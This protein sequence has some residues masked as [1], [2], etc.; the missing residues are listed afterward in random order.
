MKKSMFSGWR[1]V[2]AFTWKQGTAGKGFRAGTIGMAVLFLVIGIAINM[3]MVYGQKKDAEETS[4]IEQVHIIDESGL[5][6]LYL[7]GFEEQNQEK[8]PN[9]SFVSEEGNPEQVAAALA[10]NAEKD[11]VLHITRGEEGYQLLLII[12]YESEITEA[13][14]EE[15]NEALSIVME[16]SKLLSSGIPMEKLVMAMSSVSVSELDAGEEEKS[17]GEILA[18][19]FLP[20]LCIL[21]IYI[22]VLIYGQSISNIVTVEKSSKLMEMLLTLTRPYG[23]IFGK[24]L[25]MTLLAIFQMLLWIASLAGGFLA[26]DYI[27]RNYIYSGYQNTLLDVFSLLQGQ[28]GSTAFTAGAVLLALFTI[29]L[30]FLF[31]CMLAGLVA[32]FA[33]KA[34]EL[35]QTFA[36]YQIIVM[37]GFFGSYLV[38]LQEK[39]WMNTIV[40]CIPFTSAFL[41][42]GDILV[43]NITV[44]QGLCYVGILLASS[45]VVVLATGKVY[46]NQL[47]YKG[48]KLSSRFRKLPFFH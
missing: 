38:P 17:I 20:M 48:T 25:A 47:F 13:Q 4:P 44:L 24:I 14:G 27:A 9:V 40:R 8:F 21:V 22:M 28:E 45:F 1:E 18:S 3:F 33:S 11:V 7:E 42:P 39:E 19:I 23:L 30:S 37:L 15:L 43:G 41:L 16:Q 2:F 29:C 31:Y 5:E 12:P 46:R 26:G 6:V 36:Y 32:S 10:G 34:E 35:A